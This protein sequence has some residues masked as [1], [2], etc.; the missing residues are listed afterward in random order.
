MKLVSILTF[1]MLT[2]QTGYAISL[3]EM[4]QMAL[5]N[6][7]VIQRFVANLE[8]SEKD[9]VRARGGYFPSVDLSY[10]LNSLN[11]A[12]SLEAEENSVVY[13]VVSWNLFAGFRDRYNI[14][15]ANLLNVV[16]THR[17][18]SIHQDIQRNVA[19]RYLAVYEREANLKVT[20]DAFTTLGKIFR[21]GQSRLEVGLIDK[22]ELLKF[23]VDLDDADITMKAAQAS[24]DKSIYLLA[25]EIDGTLELENLD[26]AE[27]GDIPEYGN[28]EESEQ[29]M[30]ANRSEIRALRGLVDA[31]KMLVK[32]EYSDY[33]PQ[34][35]LEGSYLRYD[36]DFINGSGDDEEEELRAQLVLSMNLFNGFVD[37]ADIGK[38]KLEARGLQYDLVELEDTLKTELKNLYID[39]K[40]SLENVT[41]AESNIKLAKENLR[42]TQ[43]K[44]DEGLQRESD[45]L[46]AITNLSRAQFNYV[47]VIRTVFENHFRIIRMVEG[48]NEG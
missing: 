48:F 36:D 13:G 27:F 8:K 23:K 28:Q 7:K 43:L 22:N 34:L 37:E 39:Y 30:L 19:L 1:L 47:T 46:D 31:A 44:Y 16:E 45:L 38:A 29:I 25:R 24:L 18:R 10:T 40:V 5:S 2:A 20:R 42:I 3:A 21:D 15:S 26:F 41:V 12:R 17:L 6:R 32:A 14:E 33:Y 4:Q 9:I 11:E 35:D